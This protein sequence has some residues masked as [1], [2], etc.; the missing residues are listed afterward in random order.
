MITDEKMEKL[1]PLAMAGC[2]FLFPKAKSFNILKIMEIEKWSLIKKK[3]FE[4]YIIFVLWVLSK[5][6]GWPFGHQP[7]ELRYF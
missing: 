1:G 3:E 6:Y 7:Q 2:K 5:F 4:K